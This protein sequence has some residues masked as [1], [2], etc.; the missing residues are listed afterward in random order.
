MVPVDA[1]TITFQVDGGEESCD[2]VGVGDT[3]ELEPAQP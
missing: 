3:N 2:V 1:P